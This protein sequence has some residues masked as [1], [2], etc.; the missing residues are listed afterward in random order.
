MSWLLAVVLI[1]GLLLFTLLT[2]DEDRS[3][4]RCPGCGLESVVLYRKVGSIRHLRCDSCGAEYRRH[5]DG[6]L[7][8]AP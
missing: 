1:A 3:K 8:N 4:H 2:S 7:I 5:G 6:P